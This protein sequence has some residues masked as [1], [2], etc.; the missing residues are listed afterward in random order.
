VKSLT[1][2]ALIFDVDGTLAD[3]E[4]VHRAAFNEAFAEL[5]LDWHWDEVLYTRLLEV[6]GGKERIRHYWKDVRGD[7]PENGGT[8]VEAIQRIHELKTAAYARLVEGGA[9]PLLPG[10]AKLI[11]SAGKAGLRLAIA[12]TTTPANIAAL[13]RSTLG[14]DWSAKFDV[15]EDASTAPR[16]K[17]HPQVYLQTLQRM[18]LEAGEC[19]AFEDSSNGLQ[20][21]SRA[22]VP[23]IVTPNA[24]TAHQDFTAALR[25]LPSLE[26]VTIP[27]LRSWHA[28]AARTAVVAEYRVAHPLN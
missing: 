2:R 9:L 18:N 24:F 1:L 8:V 17:P 22:G 14:T 19:L 16:K 13:L 27:G 21:A 11:E 28:E 10:V 26:S 20:A 23:T 7:M 15:I 25:V 6:S 12:T 3:T 4:S 5:G